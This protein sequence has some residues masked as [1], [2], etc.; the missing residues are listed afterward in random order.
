[1]AHGAHFTMYACPLSELAII[2]GLGNVI[3]SGE[4]TVKISRN[5]RVILL[6]LVL[7]V[8][9]LIVIPRVAAAD[10]VHLAAAGDFGARATTAAVLD[11]VA[12]ASPDAMVT[13][14][15]LGYQDVPNEDA[16]CD[17]VKARVGQDF[18]FQVLSGN[19]ESND[20]KDGA[21]NNYSACL[22]NQ[23]PGIVGTYGR[24]YYMD[25]PKGAPLVRVISTSKDL[26]FDNGKWDYAQGDARYNWVS[27]SIDDARAKG[28]KWIVVANHVPCLSV[29]RYACPSNSDFYRMLV[30]KKVDL[31]L[32]GHEHG[33]MRT[34]QIRSG[35]TGCSAL[36]I[37]TYN[38]NCVA[39]SDSDF[40]AGQGT[41]FATVGTGGMTQRDITLN[42]PEMGYFAAYSGLNHNPSDGF[43][44]IKATDGELNANFVAA[45]GTGTDQFKVTRGA[46]PQNQTPT[47]AFTTT[48]NDLAVTA[49]AATSQDPDGSIAS[50]AWQFGDGSS[51]TGV[52]PAAHSYAAAGTYD[53]T[54]VVTD[55]N[56]ATNSLTK[57]VTV[58]EPNAPNIL[59]FDD[60]SKTI[61]NG[62]GTATTG[63]SWNVSSASGFSEANGVGK[64]SNPTGGGRQVMLPAVSATSTDTTLNLALDKVTTGSGLYLSLIGRSVSGAGEYRAKI[65]YRAD[66]RPSVTLI[67]TNAAGAETSLRADTL[68]PGLTY[69]AGEQLSVRFQVI[70]NGTTTLRAKIWKTGTTEPAAWLSTASDTTS[71]MQAAGSV[72]IFTYLS[73]SATNGP[74]VTSV[75]D[76]RVASG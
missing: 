18:P 22:P 73:G 37:G 6:T 9:T 38:A 76:F 75:D 39:D 2:A 23:I 16:W 11:K 65:K 33:Y 28:A 63:G 3:C 29:G 56:G 13:V 7:I 41:V 51:A 32:Q 58:T 30:D 35:A 66:G 44:D 48:T 27:N 40:V 21:I 57:S 24:Q 64:I 50:Y 68:P 61:A 62:W 60:F 46:G 14:G 19:H 49:D 55:N 72:G 34:H 20:V 12:Q 8:S 54:L 5:L 67:R 36:T 26:T 25:F 69:S 74:I 47:A 10:E 15:D 71:N 17:Y 31:V 45:T 1:M 53:V 59:A 70:G 4:H 42:D 52:K 43:L